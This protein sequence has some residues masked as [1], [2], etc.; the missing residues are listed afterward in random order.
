[1]I[2]CTSPGDERNTRHNDHGRSESEVKETEN[3]GM[4]SCLIPSE[5]FEMSRIP[6][7]DM[8]LIRGYNRQGMICGRNEISSR[9]ETLDQRALKFEGQKWISCGTTSLSFF[10]EPKCAYASSEWILKC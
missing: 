6:I 9:R 1:V 7:G 4:I 5:S 3:E 8:I 2:V 10:V